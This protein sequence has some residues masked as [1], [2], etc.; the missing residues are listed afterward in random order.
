MAG[1]QWMMDP[2]VPGTDDYLA[3]LCAEIVS[4][5]DVDGIHLD[6]IRY[7]EHSIPFNDKSTYRRYGK[8]M[9]RTNGGAATSHAA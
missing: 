8:G 9:E 4:K 6:Y 1:N 5:Y 3:N 2:G 7:P